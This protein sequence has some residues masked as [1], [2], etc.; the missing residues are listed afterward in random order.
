MSRGLSEFQNHHG[1]RPLVAKGRS[2]FTLVEILTVLV[3][4]GILSAILVPQLGGQSDFDAAAAARAVM[5]DLLYAQNRAIGTQQMQYVSFNVSQQRY[6]LYSLMSPQTVLTHPV[7]HNNYV[8][9]FGASGLNNIDAS[10]LTSASFAGQATIAFDEMGAP[11]SYNTAT[12]SVT[13][14]SSAGTVVVSSGSYSLT[15]SIEPDT[16]DMG[17][18]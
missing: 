3:I 7:N 5:S 6:G 4:L 16:G 17:V 11:Y 14:L 10:S 9:T 2:A 8:R 18:Q 1:Y 13:L 12:N 15:I